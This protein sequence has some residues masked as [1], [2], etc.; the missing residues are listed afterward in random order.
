MTACDANIRVKA[1]TTSCA[2]AENVFLAYW[3][4][5]DNPG[6]FSDSDGLP[7]YSPAAGKILA[8]HCDGE[9]VVCNAGDGGYV[10]FPMSAVEAYNADDAGHYAASH[11]TGGVSPDTGNDSSHR[12]RTPDASS[13]ECDPNYEGACLDP[14]SADYDCEG[15]SGD[16]P[17]YVGRVDV[18]GDDLYDLDRDGDGVACDA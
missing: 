6:V 14:N 8:A 2:F 1:A 5:Y 17:D 15:S 16:G 7:A 13:D 4:D 3:M 18:V 12:S 11:E 10:T 9:P